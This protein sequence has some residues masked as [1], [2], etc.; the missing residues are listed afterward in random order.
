LESIIDFS[1]VEEFID[2]PVKRYS[3]GMYVRLAFA[4]AAHLQPEILIVDEVLAVGDVDFQKKCI[5][6]MQE[7]SR[8]GRT[9]LFVSHNLQTI[10]SICQNCMVLREGNIEFTGPTHDAINYYVSGHSTKNFKPGIVRFDEKTE[11]YGTG[12][13]QIE[14]LKV[15]NSDQETTSTLLYQEHFIVEIKCLVKSP[16]SNLTVLFYFTDDEDIFHGHSSTCDQFTDPC[17]ENGYITFRFFVKTFLLPGKHYIVP[18]ISNMSR[19]IDQ[20]QR[21]FTIEV[22]HK[23]FDNKPSFPFERVRGNYYISGEWSIIH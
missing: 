19:A 21:A 14:E 20:I 2:T 22:K 3:S 8:S 5:K 4:V 23:G 9:I 15:L 6:K 17:P 1:Q 18:C 7:V 16:I 13:V 10:R 11:R 12:E